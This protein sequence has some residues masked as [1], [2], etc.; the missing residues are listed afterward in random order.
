MIVNGLGEITLRCIV[1]QAAKEVDKSGLEFKYLW[2]RYGKD[3]EPLD[4]GAYATGKE[5]LISASDVEE[6]TTFVC[7]V[8]TVALAQYTITKRNDIISS[9]TEPEIKT[10]DMLWIDTSTQKPQLKRWD[11]NQWIPLSAE[12][13]PEDQQIIERML[14]EIDVNRGEIEM[15][16]TRETFNNAISDKVSVEDVS[17]IVRQE[18]SLTVNSGEIKNTFTTYEE[19]INALE[20]FEDTVTSYQRFT[21]DG[22]ELGRSDSNITA[23]LGNDKLSFMQNNVAVAYISEHKLYVTEANVTNRLSIGNMDNGY[24]DFITTSTGL[25]L[26][27]RKQ[28]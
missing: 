3:G 1:Y 24:F 22:L 16:V 19:R 4:T 8:E 20:R 28:T 10:D 27:W 12:M 15:R 5:I 18:V 17:S 23:K 21:A 2:T 6:V 9:P 25:G 13:K 26:K 14:S 7:E 11:G